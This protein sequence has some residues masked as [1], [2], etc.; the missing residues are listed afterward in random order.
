METRYKPASAS[1]LS[2][3]R[4]K[5]KRKEN[6]VTGEIVEL[7]EKKEQLTNIKGEYCLEFFDE[8]GK[9]VEKVEAENAT[10]DIYSRLGTTRQLIDLGIQYKKGDYIWG[11]FAYP[12]FF[13]EGFIFFTQ[14]N[15]LQTEHIQGA[16]PSGKLVGM[17]TLNEAYTGEAEVA[18]TIN[19]SLC[20]VEAGHNVTKM[21]YVADFS[22]EKAN[23]TFDSVWLGHHTNQRNNQ[24]FNEMRFKV[25]GHFKNVDYLSPKFSTLNNDY[26]FKADTYPSF[27]PLSRYRYFGQNYQ[28]NANANGQGYF[29]YEATAD[30]ND[31]LLQKVEV[32]D[33]EF[34]SCEA[35]GA[36][37]YKNKPAVLKRQAV[38]TNLFEFIYFDIVKDVNYQLINPQSIKLSTASLPNHADLRLIHIKSFNNALYAIFKTVE[39][40]DKAMFYCVKYSNDGLTYY[41]HTTFT[42]DDQQHSIARD[43]HKLQHCVD[44]YRINDVDYLILSYTNNLVNEYATTYYCALTNENKM[45]TKSKLNAF[46][47]AAGKPCAIWRQL[48]ANSLFFAKSDFSNNS[49]LKLVALMPPFSHTKIQTT[50]KD[51]SQ[52]MRLTYTVKIYHNVADQY[53]PQQNAVKEDLLLLEENNLLKEENKENISLFDKIKSIFSSKS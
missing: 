42:Y 43:T 41:S 32:L 49:H 33:N 26:E 16:I 34:N 24:D 47:E 40:S 28:N 44:V 19:K 53:L 25:G 51:S 6:F 17:S 20:K 21:T 12:R 45:I 50:T 2:E 11:D 52:S 48:E 27:F 36:G 10:P 14:E 29:I 22:L 23:G 13:D 30:S 7:I 46:S 1:V 9:L 18:G 8:N 37:V 15:Q 35:G 5:K 39:D 38:S 31:V 3:I 4:D